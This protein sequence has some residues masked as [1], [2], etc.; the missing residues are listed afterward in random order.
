MILPDV[1]VL[2]YAYREDM[3]EHDRYRRWLDGVVNAGRPYGMSELV[4]SA[5][6]R[7]VTNRRV[8][9]KPCTSSEALSFTR[10]LLSPSSCVPVRAG[11]GHWEI[12]DLLCRRHA[13]AG[14]LVADA[15]LAAVAMEAGC[16]LV[17]VDR[18]FARF[19]GLRW[20][21]PLQS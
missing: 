4:L 2:V 19:T 6:V 9:R 12:F 13:V 21:H 14:N 15:Y 7:I 3:A 18:D 1:N 17:T 8:F 11:P 16:E 20:R 10:Q 5:F